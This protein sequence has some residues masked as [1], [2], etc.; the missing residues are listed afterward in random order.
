MVERVHG[1]PKQ[2]VWFSQDVRFLNIEVT[3]MTAVADLGADP[4]G[5]DSSLELVLE[6]VATRGTIIGLNVVDATN[7]SVIVDYAQAFDGATQPAPGTAPL[8]KGQLTD[9]QVVAE[10]E[11]LINANVGLSLADI[12]VFKGFVGAAQA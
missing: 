12:E 10:V 11:A 9:A 2:G 4:A 5:V 7:I 8:G 1:G 3:G 6:A